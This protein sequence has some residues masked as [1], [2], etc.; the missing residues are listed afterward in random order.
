MSQISVVECHRYILSN[1]T[2][3][4]CV[5]LYFVAVDVDDAVV[6]S[7]ACDVGMRVIA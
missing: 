7:V 2:V 1:L 6:D 3:G 5:L 4:S